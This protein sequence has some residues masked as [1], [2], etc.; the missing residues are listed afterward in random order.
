MSL[1]PEILK[2]VKLLE[3]NTRK[4]VNNLFAGEFQSAFRGQGMTF[5]EFREYV[6]GDDVRL[7]SWPLMARSG[8]LFIK[9]FDEE[10][11]MT[12]MLAVDVSGSGDF[13]SSEAMKGE[14][15][16]Y[17][18][19]ILGFSALRNKD[20]VGL[21][22][23]SDRVEHYVPAKKGRG[24]IHRILRDL[25]YFQPKS[26]QTN[27]K[28][29]VEYLQG[30]LKKKSNIFICSDFIDKGFDQSLRQLGKKHDAVAVV[31]EDP[32]ELDLPN[33]GLIDLQDPETG[34][35]YS[36]DTSSRRFRTQYKNQIA[37]RKKARDQ[38]LRKGAIDCIYVKTSDDVVDPLLAF[39]K[40]RTR[41]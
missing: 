22:L 41:R 37:E 20:P 10:R 39:F 14:V 40:R 7:I 2:K 31:V 38:D 21:L 4:M 15:I 34:E 36:V 26:R 24:H 11:E 17:V 25:F 32:V 18:A 9:K 23:F 1:P 5:S 16:A 35:V 30:V 28:L 3:I 6:P 29:A 33:L 13:G 8:K 12:L 19:A 27:I